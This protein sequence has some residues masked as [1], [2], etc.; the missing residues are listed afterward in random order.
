MPWSVGTC[1]YRTKIIK[2]I[3]VALLIGRQLFGHAIVWYLFV[4][5]LCNRYGCLLSCSCVFMLSENSH[6]PFSILSI[7]A[8]LQ[9]LESYERAYGNMVRVQ[10]L[11]ELEEVRSQFI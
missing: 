3:L 8:S 11:S 5:A 6:L 2:N 4:K 9:V 1:K 7:I 10:Q